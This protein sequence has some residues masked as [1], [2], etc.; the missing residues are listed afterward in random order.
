MRIN[1][2][3]ALRYAVLSRHKRDIVVCHAV[4]NRIVFKYDV[5]ETNRIEA[6]GI[7]VCHVESKR[8]H[9]LGY[10]LLCHIF[11][12]DARNG[13]FEDIRK[14]SAVRRAGFDRAD[15]NSAFGNGDRNFIE[16]LIA[17]S[18]HVE[19][20]RDVIYVVFVD[21][22]LY[23]VVAGVG[24]SLCKFHAVLV[25][26]TITE[27]RRRHCV[28]KRHLDGNRTRIVCNRRI[29]DG[30]IH[31]FSVRKLDVERLCIVKHTEVVL[32]VDCKFYRIVL[33]I[34]YIVFV[35]RV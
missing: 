25:K 23:E 18:V 31:H 34:I 24:R 7:V 2:D 12:S 11:G 13:V 10:T 15:D 29:G 5:V 26:V 22:N 35:I 19:V 27:A 30:I 16:E 1:V 20:R 4:E 28:R 33:C 14:I 8:E 32:V 17:L 3:I 9:S 6:L 21:K